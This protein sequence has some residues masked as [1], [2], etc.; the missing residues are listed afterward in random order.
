MVKPTKAISTASRISTKSLELR[1]VSRFVLSPTPLARASTA[2]R[3]VNGHCV[4]RNNKYEPIASLISR[5]RSIRL[6]N[7][8]FAFDGAGALG[9]LMVRVINEIQNFSEVLRG[10]KH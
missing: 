8:A 9:F 4:L 5:S 2:A 1:K 10:I 3:P 7:V 6:F